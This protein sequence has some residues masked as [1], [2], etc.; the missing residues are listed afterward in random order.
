VKCG[1]VQ[2]LRDFDY[3]RGTMEWS[4]VLILAIVQGM[5]EFLPISSSGHLLAARLFFHIPDTDG[6]V[7]DTLL[8]LGTLGAVMTYYWRTWARLIKGF[9]KPRQEAQKERQLVSALAV[10]TVPAAIVG[11][12]FEDKVD[13]FFRTP[14]MLAVS[15]IFTAVVILVLD[16]W[17]R[18]RDEKKEVKLIDALIIG[19]MQV[20][21]LVP[22]VSR[23]GI[24]IATGRWR[25]LE[26]R[27]ATDFSFM[28]SA[29]IIA[30]A[31]LSHVPDLMDVNVQGIGMLIVGLTVA[32]VSG[33]M[34]IFVLVRLVERISLAPFAVYLVALASLI[35]WYG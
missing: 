13:M 31:G 17:P 35:L 29:P 25:G 30:G 33:L 28:M 4:Q 24:T 20:L 15:L 16:W 32:F 27:Q 9:F 19:L 7:F 5:T 8:H 23:S 10:A 26:R 2:K 11:Y 34:A 22:G 1:N 14:T 21:A 18:I 3:A 6:V 12:A